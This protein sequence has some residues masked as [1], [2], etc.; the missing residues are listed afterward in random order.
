MNTFSSVGFAISASKDGKM[1]VPVSSSNYIYSH[2][3]HISGIRADEGVR[4]VT[5]NKIKILD[6]LIEQVSQSKK[7]PEPTSVSM[8]D[9]YL[10]ALIEQ[11]K[12][13]IRQTVLAS[14][15]SPYN[16][17]PMVP[18]GMIFDLVA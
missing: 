8:S 11:Y 18:M 10:D 13:Q 3:K 5:I 9:E 6:S 16:T 4:G 1:S 14:T 15:A 7:E 12:T 2:F 17:A